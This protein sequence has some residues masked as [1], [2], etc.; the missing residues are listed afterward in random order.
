MH[1]IEILGAINGST[2]F[3]PEQVLH[4][5]DEGP[6]RLEHGEAFTGR[7]RT[8][9]KCAQVWETAGPG[10]MRSRRS[11]GNA[12]GSWFAA[13]AFTDLIKADDIAIRMDGKVP[14]SI[15]GSSSVAAEAR[16]HC[17]S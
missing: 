7:D 11:R 1:A 8:V 9:V 15:T 17:N 3:T 2:V 14:R 16:D 5:L 6:Q 4:V 12:K 13:R 10:I